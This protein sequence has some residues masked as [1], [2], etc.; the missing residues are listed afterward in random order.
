MNIERIVGGSLEA[1]GYIIYHKD[2]G[3]CYII[4]PG[5]TSRVYI[6][7]VNAHNLNPLAILLTHLHSDHVGASEALADAFE[8]PIFIH[9]DDGFVYKGRVDRMLKDGDILP[10]EDENIA[11]IHTPGHTAGGVCFFLNKQR[12]VFTGDTIFDTDLGRSDL[13]GG[14]ED[15]LIASVKNVID[16]WSNDIIIYPGHDG[17]ATMKF[18]REHN[19]EFKALRDGRVR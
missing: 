18:V 2:G 9:E 10:F 14:S 12:K 11:V 13:A 4:D 15:A 17:H 8:C 6:A 19:E 16:K 3:D 5:Y 7:F 1:N